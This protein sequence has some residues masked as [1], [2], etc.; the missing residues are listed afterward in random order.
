MANIKSY[1][2]LASA[3]VAAGGGGGGGVPW[4]CK[5]SDE[6]PSPSTLPAEPLN[7]IRRCLIEKEIVNPRWE[8]RV[9]DH[10]DFGRRVSQLIGPAK[11]GEVWCV[12]C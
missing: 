8:E 6:S 4:G 10:V 2:C 1:S 5:T 12:F 11:S 7:T 3:A 9:M